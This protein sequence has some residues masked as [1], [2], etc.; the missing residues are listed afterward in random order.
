MWN[1]SC[2]IISGENKIA[3]NKL[4]NFVSESEKKAV[5]S[6]RY[7]RLNSDFLDW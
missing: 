1:V 2:L 3:E 6:N 7:F 5:K 4:D